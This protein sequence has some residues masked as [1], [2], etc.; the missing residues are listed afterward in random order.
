MSF[1]FFILG[2]M[3]IMC[4]DFVF[5]FDNIVILEL[6]FVIL[7]FYFDLFVFDRMLKFIVFDVVLYVC[8]IVVYE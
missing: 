4:M 2:L 3:V 8:G 7:V 1:M 5:V 6:F